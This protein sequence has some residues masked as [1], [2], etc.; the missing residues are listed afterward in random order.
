MKDIQIKYVEKAFTAF[1]DSP[2]TGTLGEV[3]CLL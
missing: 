2:F 3:Y 1:Q